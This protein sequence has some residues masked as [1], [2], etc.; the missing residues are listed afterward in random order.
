MIVGVL[1]GLFA[2]GGAAAPGDV[3]VILLHGLGRTPL[4]MLPLRFAVE[5]AGFTAV[6]YGY[7]SLASPIDELS[8]THIP[9][10]LAECAVPSDVPVHFVTHSLGGIVV[11]HYL[12]DHT[13][14]AG[15][16]MVMLGPPNHGSELIDEFASQ[17]W[18]AVMGPAALQ[19]GTGPDGLLA[20]LGAVDLEIGVIAGTRTGLDWML[21]EAATI[22]AP[23]DGKVSLESARLE[24][25]R[26]FVTV[27]E[28]HTFMLNDSLVIEQVIAFLK[29]G[30]FDPMDDAATSA[31]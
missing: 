18:F 24:E 21:Q 31:D 5:G 17:P 3:C 15:S 28:S 12:Q 13:L 6:N 9:R 2:S 30:R 19:L 25:M 11:R 14:P 23:N 16:R 7:P 27:D 20:T 10:A 8:G 1:L 29:N 4:S 22:A 26:D